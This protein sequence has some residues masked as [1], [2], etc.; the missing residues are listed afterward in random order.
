MSS[1]AAVKKEIESVSDSCENNGYT[2][3]KN[4]VLTSKLANI[5]LSLIP[6]NITLKIDDSI[7]EFE[8]SAWIL[9]AGED[10][11]VRYKA[12]RYNKW[13]NKFSVDTFGDEMVKVIKAMSI[14]RNVRFD[15]VEKD[16]DY[17]YDLWYD[18]F[19]D[20]D[21]TIKELIGALAK[22]DQEI[23]N[24]TETTLNK[25]KSITISTFH[26]LQDEEVLGD[27]IEI[28]ENKK[29]EFKVKL[30]PPSILARIIAAFRNTDGGLILIGLR[31]SK[32]VQGLNKKEQMKF[33]DWVESALC[34]VTPS[35]KLISYGLISYGS[36]M[37]G[38]ILVMPED[39]QFVVD[40]SIFSRVGAAT[41]E[42]KQEEYKE[43]DK[44]KTA[45]IPLEIT[46]TELNRFMNMSDEDAFTEL[47]LVP[48]L[49]KMG[50]RSVQAKGHVDRTLEFGQDLRSFKFELPTGHWLYFAAQVKTEDLIYS[51]NE[52]SGKE[53][54][55]KVLLQVKMAFSHEMFDIETNSKVLPDHVLL[56]TTGNVNEGAREHLADSLS[57]EKQRRI[58]VW[59]GDL[60]SE[61]ISKI[62]LPPGC[63]Q[64]I[65]K[66]IEAKK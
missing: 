37:L 54:I 26:S 52:S 55:E 10:Y 16:P 9:N 3:S 5:K 43:F 47:L 49:R 33:S 28:G 30:P 27:I 31:D 53:N 12:L 24:Q 25:G 40:G 32:N 39:L 8:E 44:M 62:G 14:N 41:L 57:R 20:K 60:I 6:K 64:E 15:S 13:T 4:K 38:G 63:Q 45:F 46:D 7:A 22:I 36:K 61:R 19:T 66:Y 17:S 56:I 35:P 29:I 50:F 65:R 2:L 59:Y 58:L 23:K 51:A 34:I 21:L 48:L 42:F 1:E 11:A 18:V